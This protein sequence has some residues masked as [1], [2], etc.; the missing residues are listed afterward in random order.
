MGIGRERGVCSPRDSRRPDGRSRRV[1]V[2]GA[3]FIG[4]HIAGTLA[5]SGFRI[6]VIT[7][8]EPRRQLA[9]LLGGVSVLLADV[10]SMNAV[11][12]LLSEVDHIVYAVGSS[13]PVESDLDPASDVSLVVP[14]VVRLLEL[15]RLRPTVGLT[16]LSSGGAV[17]G[18]IARAVARE[19]DP[20]EPISSYGI[21]KLTVEKY[22]FMYAAVF[23]LSVRVLRVSNAYGPGQ[24]WA[25]GQG[26]VPR[27][28][29][30]ALTGEQFP[31]YGT[32]ESIRDYVFINDVSAAVA[33]LLLRD[34]TEA[35][36][37]IGSGVGHS[38]LD[39]I[40]LVESTTGKKINVEYWNARSFDVTSIVLDI[41]RLSKEINYEPTDLSTGLTYT[42]QAFCAQKGGSRPS[43]ASPHIP[44]E[45]P[46]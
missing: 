30:C 41:S 33:A 18:N 40:R 16:Y 35:L 43:S 11:R 7:R 12:A 44:T 28:M 24:P 39:V 25:K 14:P 15:L 27:L 10:S 2:L 42:W 3:G 45:P 13:S 19:D 9:R 29:S 26:I 23:G 46:L 31:V 5:K 6:D 22:L 32:G 34:S 4:A 21:L 38:I 8:S 17:Y 20:T 36:L 1:L 37:N